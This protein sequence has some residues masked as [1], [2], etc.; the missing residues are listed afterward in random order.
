[1]GGNIDG[2]EAADILGSSVS[3]SSDGSRVAIGASEFTSFGD[4]GEGYVRVYEWDGVSWT[5]IGEDIEGEAAADHSG[6]SVSLSS[7]GSRVAIGSPGHD[8]TDTDA[9]QVRVY[10]WNGGSWTPMGEDFE[11]EAAEDHS[12]SSV[13]L[14]SDGNQVAIGTPGNDG[15]GTDAGQVRVYEFTPVATTTL[16]E[17]PNIEIFPN[18]SS[19][20]IELIGVECARVI[21]IDY[22][23]R[24]TLKVERS[25]SEIDISDLAAGIYFLQINAAD[26]WI[27][28]KLIKI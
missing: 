24:V 3:L 21:I 23:G 13:S 5:Q 16:E 22:F 19:G 1:M 12:G 6:S 20:K 14:S 8:G 2:E 7:D 11:G 17:K 15:N 28:K 25:E 10:E 4:P 18:P 27:S 9:G 26:Q